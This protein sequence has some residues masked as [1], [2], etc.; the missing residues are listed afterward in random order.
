MLSGTP[1]Q[2]GQERYG[3]KKNLSITD[4]DIL[5][6][7]GP[8]AYVQVCESV[9]RYGPWQDW[10]AKDILCSTSAIPILINFIEIET[11]A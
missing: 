8:R 7:R 6:K 3:R 2:Q 1:P 4:I 5:D 9:V 10:I 11:S